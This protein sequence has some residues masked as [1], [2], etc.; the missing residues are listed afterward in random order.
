MS[1]NVWFREW[2]KTKLVPPGRGAS[3][4]QAEPETPRNNVDTYYSSLVLNIHKIKLTS[5]QT[6]CHHQEKSCRHQLI[7][8]NQLLSC[9]FALH[10][11]TQ[12]YIHIHIHNYI[13]IHMYTTIH[14]HVH[15][16]TYTCAQLYT[17]IH[18]YTYTYTTIHTQLYIHMCTTIHTHV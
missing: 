4:E 1:V 12:L 8:N 11:H 6:L 18:N 9:L 17:H 7:T 3:R 5:T 14:T 15:N 10:T 16:Y 13:Y 2:D